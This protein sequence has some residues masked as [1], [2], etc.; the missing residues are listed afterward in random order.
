MID[1]FNNLSLPLIINNIMIYSL[2]KLLI[3]IVTVT[4]ATVTKADQPSEDS[5]KN[6]VD[7]I[8]NA[9]DNLDHNP[10]DNKETKE[11]FKDAAKTAEFNDAKFDEWFSHFDANGDGKLSFKE[12]KDMAS[13]ET[14]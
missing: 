14:S 1:R 2:F 13:K 12:L 5:V 4:L 11:F 7:N 6:Y 8:L 10:L 9:F 3:L